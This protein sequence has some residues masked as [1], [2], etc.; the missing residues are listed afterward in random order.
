MTDAGLL[1]VTDLHPL[2]GRLALG[3]T[4]RLTDNG[5]DAARI[6]LL[7]ELEVEGFE[8]TERTA[9]ELPPP[10]LRADGAL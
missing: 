6:G 4:G 8:L 2:G 3:E 7:G 1:V 5:L 10:E 9:E